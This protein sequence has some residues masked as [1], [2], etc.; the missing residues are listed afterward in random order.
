MGYSLH[1]VEKSL[2]LTGNKS[3][4]AAMDWLDQNKD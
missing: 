2:L 1:P 3:V 4:E